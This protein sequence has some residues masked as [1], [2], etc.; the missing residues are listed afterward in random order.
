MPE[1]TTDTQTHERRRLWDARSVLNEDE[2]AELYGDLDEFARL[3][4]AAQATAG[5]VRLS[6]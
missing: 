1:L 3:R 6:T 5:E 4:R 2:L